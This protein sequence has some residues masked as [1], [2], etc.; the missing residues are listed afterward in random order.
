VNN[1]T[2]NKLNV[3]IKSESTMNITGEMS[4]KGA[5][6]V[7]FMDKLSSIILYTGISVSLISVAIIAAIKLTS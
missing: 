3:T 6:R 5:D 4:Q 1:N 7:G 2:K